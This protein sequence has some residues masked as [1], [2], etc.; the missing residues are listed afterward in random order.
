MTERESNNSNKSINMKPTRTTA[1]ILSAT[2]LLLAALAAGVASCTTDSISDHHPG[3]APPVRFTTGMTATPRTRVGSDEQGRTLWMA[4]DSVGIFMVTHD[5]TLVEPRGNNLPY[6]ALVSSFSVPFSA[7]AQPIRLPAIRGKR[8]DF[9]AYYPYQAG[10]HGS[11]GF[12]L[13][14]T[15]QSSQSA[16][17][18]LYA[19]ADNN[20]NGYSRDDGNDNTTVDFRFRHL[21]TKLVLRVSKHPNVSGEITGVTIN[22]IYPNITVDFAKDAVTILS[23]LKDITPYTVT[24]G[25]RY[26]AILAPGGGLDPK[27]TVTFTTSDGARYTWDIYKQIPTGNMEF[28]KL[29]T[30]DIILTR[31]AVSATLSID[32]WQEDRPE[33]GGT[34]T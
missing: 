4:G 28:G 24:P 6:V 31:Y 15:D 22:K 17:D 32:P 14:L 9:I 29:Y 30:F 25:A 2:L 23:E 27:S 13:D 3:A 16:L 34:A 33:T 12:N 7:A 5:T 11:F 20:G 10:V 26:E 21:L 8:V 18:V 19:R 1:H